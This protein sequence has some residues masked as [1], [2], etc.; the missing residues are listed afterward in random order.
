MSLQFVWQGCDSILAAPL[1][2][3]LVRLGE[4]AHRQGEAGPMV[5]LACFFKDPMGVRTH[6]FI[7]QFRLLVKY[8]H[9]HAKPSRPGAKPKRHR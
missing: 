4:F 6:A 1:V 3:D 8:V 2:L 9:H 7:D 5:H